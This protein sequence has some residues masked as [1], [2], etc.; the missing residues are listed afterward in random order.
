LL[1]FFALE[2]N[3]WA[4]KCIH[5]Y[6]GLGVMLLMVPINILTG[7]KMKKYQKAQ[8]LHKDQRK[9]LKLYA[10]EPSFS[11]KLLATREQEVSALKKVR[12]MVEVEALKSLKHL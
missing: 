6:T 8:M 2:E 10:W 9:V 1:L 3:N 11:E 7:N 4:I 5:R 12:V